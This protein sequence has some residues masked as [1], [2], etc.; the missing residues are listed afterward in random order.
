MPLNPATLA[1]AL[2]ELYDFVHAATG[3]IP[4]DVLAQKWTDAFQKYMT[5]AVNPTANPAA[6]A[7]GASAMQPVLSAT[8]LRPPPAGLAALTA[9]LTAFATAFALL[10]APFIS[11][12]PPAPLPPP[13][14]VPGPSPIAAAAMAATI[15]TWAITGTASIPPAPP[16]LWA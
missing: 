12:P 7:A 2:T 9:G 11:T 8:I 10:T 5:E 3:P 14:A 1:D 6:L 15:H 13:P 16:I 4:A